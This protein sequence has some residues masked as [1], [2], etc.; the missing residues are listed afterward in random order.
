MPT[1]DW[2]EDPEF[3]YSDV[4][5][6][7]LVQLDG[8]LNYGAY[9]QIFLA[10]A[11]TSGEPVVVKRSRSELEDNDPTGPAMREYAILS[12]LRGQPNIVHAREF[13]FGRWIIEENMPLN[14][15]EFMH[16]HKRTSVLHSQRTE[17]VT[18][19]ME[20]LRACH[21]HSIVHRD[22]TPKNILIDPGPPLRV[23]L[24]DFGMSKA[25]PQP[26]H[27]PH[28]PLVVTLWY[29]APELLEGKC[30][31]YG[32]EIDIWALGCVAY[33]IFHDGYPLFFCETEM[34]MI[35]AISKKPYDG[36]PVGYEGFFSRVLEKSPTQRAKIEEA[37]QLFLQAAKVN[38]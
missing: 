36:I 8:R 26:N 2:T 4:S 5:E 30:V 27:L 16:K 17:I 29:R 32:P 20:G 15:L 3:W 21:A 12:K 13:E 1:L 31:Y 28:T 24:C 9:G 6:S 35:C 37:K 22:L 19:V 25:I 11:R 14:L 33:Q 10:R 34:E 18:Q 38:S 23:K 7:R